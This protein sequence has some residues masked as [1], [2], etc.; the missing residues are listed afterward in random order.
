MF[1]E[2]DTC[3]SMIQYPDIPLCYIQVIQQIQSGK[4]LDCPRICP[5]EVRKIMLGCWRKPPNERLSM[6]E[7]KSRLEKVE[8]EEKQPTVYLEVIG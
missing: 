5:E 2:I 3:F 8:E 1:Q 6:R 7:I 4:I